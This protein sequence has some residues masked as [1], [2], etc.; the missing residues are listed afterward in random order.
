MDLYKGNNT[1]IEAE[2]AQYHD[3][4]RANFVDSYDNLTLKRLAM[5]N[6]VST[7]CPRAKYLLKS[8]DDVY[9]NTEVLLQTLRNQ[10]SVKPR[11][12]ILGRI[13]PV[14]PVPREDDIPKPNTKWI[15]SR[16]EFP[17]DIYPSYMLGSAYAMTC[18]S[19][20][21]LYAA[22][23]KV[24]YMKIEDVFITGLCANK[25]G[26]RRIKM[27]CLKTARPSKLKYSATSRDQLSP[28]LMRLLHI[29][30]QNV[31]AV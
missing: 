4:V 7:F 13:H 22:S 20:P 31:T 28:T 6:W 2:N 11:K 26:I 23:L 10:S 17:D 25:A 30:L 12:F 21:D 15:M 5:L 14:R 16:K 1:F 18:S 24:H 19:V 9:V 29:S 3:I 8:D 27:N